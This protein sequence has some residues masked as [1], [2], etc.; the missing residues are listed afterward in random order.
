MYPLLEASQGTFALTATPQAKLPLGW[1]GDV[2]AMDVFGLLSTARSG[3]RFVLACIDHF[4]RWIEVIALARVTEGQVVK[5]LRDVWTHHHGVPRL[6][7][8][9]N[10][11]QFISEV[12]RNLSVSIGE[13]KIYSTA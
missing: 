2:L 11:P 9:D 1:P 4:S 3:A 12:L 7:L 6:I 10:G 8:S 13:R 5:P